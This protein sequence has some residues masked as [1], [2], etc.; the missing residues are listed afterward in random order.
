VTNYVYIATSLDGF[1]ADRDG[2]LDWLTGV[3]DPEGG[4]IPLFGTLGRALAFRH[5]GTEEL[6]PDLVRNRHVR[7]RESG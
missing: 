4:G 5:A 6:T 3:S 7:D 2:G 1:I